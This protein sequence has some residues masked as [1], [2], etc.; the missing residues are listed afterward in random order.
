MP[1]RARISV[2]V[3][4]HNRLPELM[5]AVER[6]LS[7]PEQPPVIVVDNASTHFTAK[8]VGRHFPQV[9]VLRLKEN[10]GAAARNVGARLARTPYVAFSDDDTGWAPGSL[11]R[12]VELLDQYPNIAALSARVLVGPAQREDPAC[13]EMAASP[14][15]SDGLPGRAVLGFLAGAAVFRRAAFLEAGGYEPR[16]FVGGEEALLALDLTTRGWALVYT[17]ELV[18]FHHP[19][20][21]RDAVLRRRVQ[22]RNALWVLWLR[23]SPLAALRQTLRIIRGALDDRARIEG[24]FEALRGVPWVLRNR[25]V[26]PAR[27]E[28]LCAQIE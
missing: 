18:A 17:D 9:Q 21:Y 1:H 10:I 15:P 6:S 8:L 5:R 20:V 13:L 12:A 27:V 11:A 25:R 24:V 2:V 14:L 22:T 3:L 28:A 23:R 16:L 26:L 19:S 4:T 7:L